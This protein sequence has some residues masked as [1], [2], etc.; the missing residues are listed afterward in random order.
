MMFYQKNRNR[1]WNKMALI[2]NIFT[3]ISQFTSHKWKIN[4]VLVYPSFDDVQQLVELM[5][6]DIETSGYDSIESGGILIKKS[7]GKTDVY[8]HLGEISE[9]SSL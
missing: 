6:C 8:V 7:G 2:D 3:V 5:S 4:G 1:K 9:D